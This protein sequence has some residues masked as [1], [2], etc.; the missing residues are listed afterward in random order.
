MSFSTGLYSGTFKDV[1]RMQQ[2]DLRVDTVVRL[3]TGERYSVDAADAG[4]GALLNNG[5]YANPIETPQTVTNKTDIAT[6]NTNLTNLGVVIPQTVSGTLT[7]GGRINQL[8]DSGAFTLPLANSVTADTILV[9]E[10]PDRYNAQTPTVTRSGSDTITDRNGTDTV[11]N[12]VGAAKLTL[13][14]DGVS[15]WSL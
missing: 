14:S 4:S 10:L 7:A 13:T 9:V 1:A 15:D 2:A 3:T 6:L 5:N 12:F 11:I 8:R